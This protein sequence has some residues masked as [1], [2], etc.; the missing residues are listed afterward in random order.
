MFIQDF[1]NNVKK[2]R[3]AQRARKRGDKG[4]A[5]DAWKLEEIVDRGLAEGVTVVEPVEERL[6]LPAPSA[7]KI[8]NLESKQ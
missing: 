2:M 1:V 6:K 8:M 7:P 5:I 3:Q 4:A